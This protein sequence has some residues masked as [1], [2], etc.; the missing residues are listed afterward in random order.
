[1]VRDIVQ[2]VLK[3][4][5]EVLRVLVQMLSRAMLLKNSIPLRYIRLYP[6]VAIT[7]IA[8]L[9]L[10]VVVNQSSDRQHRPVSL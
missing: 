9:A 2:I 7:A 8:T 1:M 5:R 3:E 10:A 4:C 6:T